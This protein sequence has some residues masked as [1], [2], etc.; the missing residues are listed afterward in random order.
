M[1]SRHTL[2]DGLRR[3]TA[4]RRRLPTSRSMGIQPD[5]CASEHIAATQAHH[6]SLARGILVCARPDNMEA[7]AREP[8]IS[9][10]RSQESRAHNQA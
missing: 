10:W 4:A 3:G 2:L 1:N 8:K 5:D 7:S 6:Q 9:C